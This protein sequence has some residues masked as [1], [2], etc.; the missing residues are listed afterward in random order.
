MLRFRCIPRNGPPLTMNLGRKLALVNLYRAG[1]RMESER[2]AVDQHGRNI[3]A[4]EV[5]DSVESDSAGCQ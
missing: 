1:A 4:G 2:F 3:R 5:T